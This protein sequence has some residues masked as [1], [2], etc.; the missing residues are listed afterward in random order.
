[1][2]LRWSG[3]IA[4]LLQKPSQKRASIFWLPNSDLVSTLSRANGVTY[5]MLKQER[6]AKAKRAALREIEYNS[7]VHQ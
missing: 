3:K 1:M 4:V 6:E 2:S 7:E 5:S